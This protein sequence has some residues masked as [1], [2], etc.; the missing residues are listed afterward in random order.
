MSQLLI[1][2]YYNKVAY[3]QTLLIL[4]R[5]E[6]F[7]DISRLL[8]PYGLFLPRYSWMPK[9][10]SVL[11][12][13]YTNHTLCSEFFSIFSLKLEYNFFRIKTAENLSS[14]CPSKPGGG[15]ICCLWLLRI[16]GI[17]SNWHHSLNDRVTTM[18]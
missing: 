13:T 8:F 15:L 2:L 6:S 7:S 9:L 16:K 5:G 12:S 18:F 4:R 1:I 17:L 14:W 10:I 11:K 3:A